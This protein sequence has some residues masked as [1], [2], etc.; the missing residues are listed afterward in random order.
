MILDRYLIGIRAEKRHKYSSFFIITFIP[1][2]RN[3]DC[4]SQMS[5][6]K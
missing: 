4:R 5:E 3:R 2:N 1:V 6:F